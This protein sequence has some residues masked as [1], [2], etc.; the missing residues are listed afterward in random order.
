MV[1]INYVH[2]KEPQ[3]L[4]DLGSGFFVLFCCCCLIVC[5]GFGFVF[6]IFCLFGVFLVDCFDF[7]DFKLC[8]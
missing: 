6:E 7:L 3:I 1:S 5:V 2:R 8:L 4:C